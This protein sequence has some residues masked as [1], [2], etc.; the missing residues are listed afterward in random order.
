MVPGAVIKD[1]LTLLEDH[2][3][4]EIRR[5]NKNQQLKFN[6]ANCQATGTGTWDLGPG[7]WDLGP[8]TWDLGPR[9]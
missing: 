7:T 3:K 4:E 6:F 5:I 9:T 1:V 8:G 2:D